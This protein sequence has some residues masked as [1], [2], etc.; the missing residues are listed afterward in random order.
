MLTKTLLTLQSAQ[1]GLDVHNVLAINVPVNSYG[2][3]P[4]QNVNFYKETIRRIKELPS[5]DGVA[6]GTAV[7]WRDATSFGFGLEFS[8]DG[9][10]K[11]PGEQDP[12]LGR[13]LWKGVAEVFVDERSAKF[14]HIQGEPC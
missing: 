1:T 7:P 12:R 14:D 6:V 13:H 10:V 11:G 8:A 2:R 9:H 5:V 4:E 3:T